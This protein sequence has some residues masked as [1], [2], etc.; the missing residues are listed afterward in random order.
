[1]VFPTDTGATQVTARV[2]SRLPPRRQSSGVIAMLPAI[3]ESTC[4]VQRNGV[5]RTS[6]TIIEPHVVDGPAIHRTLAGVTGAT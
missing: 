1:M 2:N 3:Y 6:G 5:S 4:I